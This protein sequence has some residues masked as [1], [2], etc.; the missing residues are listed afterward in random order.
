MGHSIQSMVYFGQLYAL[1]K[2]T[3][4]WIIYFKK[5]QTSVR[6]TNLS[7]RQAIAKI[8]FVLHPRYTWDNLYRV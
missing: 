8:P 2:M 4:F 5:S 1:I 6:T 7:Q 3:Y